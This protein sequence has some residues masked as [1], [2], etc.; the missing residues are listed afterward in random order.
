MAGSSPIQLIARRLLS[1]GEHASLLG[2]GGVGHLWAQLLGDWVNTSFDG[3]G[4]DT[5]RRQARDLFTDASSKRHVTRVFAEPASRLADALRRNETVDIAE[6]ARI[7]VGRMVADLLGLS[8]A[9]NQDDAAFRTIFA[10]GER[11]AALARGTLSSTVIPKDTLAEAREILEHLTARVPEAYETADKN[12]LLGRCRE[13]GIP[14]REARGL[15]SL[16]LV[17]GTETAA[18]AMARGVALL[19]DT[20][21]QHDL[22]AEPGLLPGAVW[23][24]LRVTTPAPLIGRHITADFSASGKIL[25]RG[26]RALMLTYT[27]NN[28]VGPFDIRRSPDRQ[29]RQLWFGAGPHVCLGAPLARA[30]MTYLLQMLL[31]QERPW[32]IVHRR[33]ARKVIIPTYAQLE[34]TC[35]P[36]ESRDA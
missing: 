13:A 3:P 23:E 8:I 27:I 4:H 24:I 19:H 32:R 11:L 14:L 5:L 12:A 28:A 26:E 7:W 2:E 18:S 25:R 17:A 34:I 36:R 1:D 15:A 30:E 6:T 16:L 22:R 31:A 33:A 9:N 35:A 21:Q 29:I 10:A 20:G